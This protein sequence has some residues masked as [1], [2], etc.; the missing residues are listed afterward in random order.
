MVLPIFLG[1]LTTFG[2]S[3]CGFT[4][5]YAQKDL[6]HLNQVYVPMLANQ[7][8]FIL[9]KQLQ[10]QLR[11]SSSAR[12]HARI[13]FDEILEEFSLRPD[14]SAARER[15]TTIARLKLIDKT[16][17][18]AVYRQDFSA[19]SNIDIVS[20]SYAVISAEDSAVRRNLNNLAQQITANIALYFNKQNKQK[21]Q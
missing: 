17:G 2:L 21:K 9:R 7:E 8:G 12:Y 20:S 18:R 14:E 4:P 10:T 5:L 19:D 6:D 3:G 1:L 13:D 11:G 16:T 15:L